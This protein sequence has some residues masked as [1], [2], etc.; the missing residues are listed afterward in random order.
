MRGRLA[1]TGY[2][3]ASFVAGFFF[4]GYLAQQ[5]ILVT[6]SEP[7]EYNIG[8]T[9]RHLFPMGLSADRDRTIECEFISDYYGDYF[10]RFRQ[11]SL[12]P[13]SVTVLPR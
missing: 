8:I 11:G 12:P 2:L 9:G 4:C 6:V 13:C 10:A 1:F 7:G 5:I 3:L